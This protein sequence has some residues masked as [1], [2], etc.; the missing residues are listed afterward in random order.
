MKS[1]TPDLRTLI[2]ATVFAITMLAVAI[3]LDASGALVAG[4]LAGTAAVVAATT[5]KRRR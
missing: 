3:L 4:V 1:P 5:P 2:F